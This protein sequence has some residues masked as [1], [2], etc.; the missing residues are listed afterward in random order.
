MNCFSGHY[1]ASG[2][3]FFLYII[4]IVGSF[5]TGSSKMLFYFTLNAGVSLAIETGENGEISS[6][7]ITRISWRQL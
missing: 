1:T 3:E 4:S 6:E 2:F 7:I 5:D